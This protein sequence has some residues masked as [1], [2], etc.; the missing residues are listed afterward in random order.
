MAPFSELDWATVWNM[1]ESGVPVKR[2]AKHLNLRNSS[3]RRF[4]AGHVDTRPTSRQRSEL[5][6]VRTGH[7]GL[8]S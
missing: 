4:I 3:L 2:I 7:G 5:R 1:R 6:R 8:L